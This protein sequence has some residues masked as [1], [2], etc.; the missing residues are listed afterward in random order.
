MLPKKDQLSAEKLIFYV[1]I[2]TIIPFLLWMYL[3]LFAV[4]F[5]NIAASFAGCSSMDVTVANNI[6]ALN[7]TTVKIPCIFTSCYKIDTTKFAMN[8][9]YQET[10]NDTEEMVK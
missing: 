7:G 3:L 2:R 1:K 6:N 10:L 8:W 9:T 5:S 4:T